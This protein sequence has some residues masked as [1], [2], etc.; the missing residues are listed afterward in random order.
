MNRV[1]SG[2]LTPEEQ[3]QFSDMVERVRQLRRHAGVPD[4][5]TGEQAVAMHIISSQELERARW[6]TAETPS[7]EQTTE[8]ADAR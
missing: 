5:M 4:G 7:T 3:K 1:Q 6:G 8:V 2:S